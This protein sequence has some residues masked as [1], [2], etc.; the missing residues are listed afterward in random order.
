MNCQA[1]VSLARF[2]VPVIGCSGKSISVG[3]L[4]GQDI[5]DG[6]GDLLEHQRAEILPVQA[7]RLH[8]HLWLDASAE[9]VKK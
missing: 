1:L 4:F 5:V 7:G 2:G 6:L 9:A 3:K 8:I